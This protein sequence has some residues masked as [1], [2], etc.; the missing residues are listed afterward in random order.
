MAA[1][2]KPSL[3]S[4]MCRMAEKIGSDLELALAEGRVTAEELDAMG[5]KCN[6][7]PSHYDCIRWQLD[8][9]PDAEPE[10]FCP[11]IDRLNKL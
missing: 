4:L 2:T 7:C 10:E 9:G 5:Q 8:V 11:N 6:H 1:P 3:P